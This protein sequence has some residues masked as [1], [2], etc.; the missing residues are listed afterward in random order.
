MRV[1]A[2]S[3]F[4]VYA[5][6]TT[7]SPSVRFKDDNDNVVD[8][9]GWSVEMIRWAAT[10]EQTTMPGVVNGDVVEFP[11]LPGDTD[12]GITWLTMVRVNDGTDSFSLSSPYLRVYDLA[13]MFCAVPDVELIV[14][15]GA[16]SEWEI[17][18]AIKIATT[19]VRAWVT[20]P[21][22][23]PVPDRVRMAT[24]LLAARALTSVGAGSGSS[25]EIVEERIADYSVRYATSSGGSMWLI[26]GEVADLLTPWKMRAYDTNIGSADSTVYDDDGYVPL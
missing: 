8:P 18:A 19:V 5:G 22:G 4:G 6:D 24:A 20:K 7:P 12:L 11:W 23:S 2:A 9:S 1:V 14:G 3:P 26:D 21:V 25:A 10:G 15:S 17:L 16:Y 13:D